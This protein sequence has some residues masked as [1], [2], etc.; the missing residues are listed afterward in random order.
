MR[1]V[2]AQ[3]GRMSD[4]AALSLGIVA[5]S[6]ALLAVVKLCEA[7]PIISANLASMQQRRLARL[8]LSSLSF[9]TMAV[10]AFAL[11]PMGLGTLV[12]KI[13]LPIKARS[14]FQ[15]PVVFLVTDCWSLGLILTK[16]AWGF[17]QM[18]SVAL[19]ALS[20]EF[21]AIWGQMQG[22]FTNLFFDLS[23][24]VRIWKG[25][26]APPLEE[27][28]V[29]LVFPSALAHTLCLY[30]IPEQHTFVK[31]MVLMYSYHAVLSLRLSVAAV[32]GIRRW[33]TGV[34]QGIFDAKYLV[35]TELQN[36]H[37]IHPGRT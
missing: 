8:L 3:A 28:V 27:I 34:R 19:H 13:M 7:L 23:L 5:F 35:S 6:A 18:E 29:Q 14:V 16:V 26:I 21:N 32:P 31:A 12:L 2:F 22:S 1:H 11:I 15:T 33:L 30:C 10:T 25:L 20:V 36:Y 9:T 24:H 17:A 4:F 37:P